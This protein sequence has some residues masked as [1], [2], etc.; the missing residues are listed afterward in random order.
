MIKKHDPFS[1]V[2]NREA[3]VIKF[4]P[5]PL[6]TKF[7]QLLTE[8]CRIGPRAPHTNQEMPTISNVIHLPCLVRATCGNKLWP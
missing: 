7:N 5:E 3:L 1:D 8:H 4:D 6:V 2:L